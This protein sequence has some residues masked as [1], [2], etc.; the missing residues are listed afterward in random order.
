MLH[1]S[2]TCG[3]PRAGSAS[4][5]VRGKGAVATSGWPQL[6]WQGGICHVLHARR[7]DDGASKGP[8]PASRALIHAHSSTH[9]QH[10]ASRGHILQPGH[11]WWPAHRLLCCTLGR[12]VHTH[13]HTRSCT[14]QHKHA[15]ASLMALVRRGPG[16]TQLSSPLHRDEGTPWLQPRVRGAHASL[17]PRRSLTRWHP[18]QGTRS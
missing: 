15:R 13:T 2:V 10:T 9:I 1:E 14:G 11:G 3:S 7:G 17:S 5:A 4:Q 12:G 8:A 18:A 16:S 6:V